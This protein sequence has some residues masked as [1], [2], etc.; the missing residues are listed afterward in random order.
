[1]KSR[2]FAVL[3]ASWVLSAASFAAPTTDS[4]V[5]YKQGDTALEGFVSVPTAKSARKRPAV[6]VVHEWYGLNDYAK[7]RAR[8]IAS[9]FGYVG[10]AADIY[11]KGVLAKNDEEAGKL[12]GQYRNNTDRTVLRQRILAAIDAVKKR[13]D[14]DPKKVVVMGY[15][16]GGSTALEAGYAGADVAGIASFHGGLA[17]PHPEDAKNI[18]GKVIVFHGGEDPYVSKAEVDTLV[19]NLKKAKID[20]QLVEYSDAV[21]GFTNAEHPPKPGAGMAY[22]EKADRRSWIGLKDFLAETFRN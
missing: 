6:V 5:E 13:P 19:D 17:T 14:V 1:M 18:K 10:F 15:C 7:K 12:A 20:W 8:M 3:A 16:F 9:E 2:L 4:P 22:N 11:G 21:H